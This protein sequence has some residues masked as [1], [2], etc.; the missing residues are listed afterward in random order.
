MPRPPLLLLPPSEGKADG[1]RPSGRPDVFAAALTGPRARVLG[2]LRRVLASRRPSVQVRVLGVRGDL[3]VRAV[4]AT[5]ALVDGTAPVL[6]AWRRYT[7]VVWAGLDPA[8]LSPSSR[9]RV[10]VPSAVYGMTT[11]ADPVA[12]Y[13]LKFLVSLGRLGRLSTFWRPALTAA[14]ADRA[15]GRLVV[16]L[17]PAEHAHALDL[18]EL[19]RTCRLVRVRFVAADGARPVGH[20]AKSAKGHLARVLLDEGLEGAAGFDRDGWRATV[21]DDVV[22]VR[23][24]RH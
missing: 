16:D 12:D 22:T 14:V 11:A 8:T 2:E 21:D 9:G 3:L 17:L 13:R 7:G 23:A 20:E 10:L 18:R 5:D 19:S 15:A 1:G 6:P 4:A 24:P